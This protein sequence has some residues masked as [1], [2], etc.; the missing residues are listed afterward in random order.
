MYLWVGCK[1][2]EEFEQEIRRHCL[3]LNQ[4][5]GLDTVAFELPQHISLKISFQAE[6]PDEILAH[7]EAFLST[8]AP[9]DVQILNAEQFGQ[10]LWLTISEN[11]TLN[12][13]HAE[14]DAQLEHRFEIPQHEFDKCFKFHSTLFMDADTQKVSQMYATLKDYPFTRKLTVDTFLLGQSE[15][16]KP[17]TC[18]I[19]RRIKV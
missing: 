18:S 3:I 11:E 17:G 4:L 8:Q 6:H 19:V 10:I 2:P 15:T 9:F 5:I 1:L 12:R 13:L 16:G 14:L 7:L